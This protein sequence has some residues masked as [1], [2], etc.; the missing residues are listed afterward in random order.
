MYYRREMTTRRLATPPKP[1]RRSLALAASD[2]PVPAKARKGDRNE[3]QTVLRACEVLK[4]FRNLGEELNLSQVIER[5]G[6][7][8]TTVFRLLR[9]LIHGGLLERAGS[10]VYRN[11]FGPVTARPFR[12]GFAAQGDSEFCRE[13]MKSMEV[14]AAREHVHLITVNNR[15]SAREAIRNADILI[16]EQ[17][18]LVLEFQTYERVAPVLSSKF[19]EANV[20]VIA[21][22]IPHPGA[23]YFGAN[24]YKA[25]II[26]GKALGRWARDH[27]DGK[28]DQLLL[29]E[30]PIAGSLLELR[31]TGLVDGLRAELPQITSVPVAHLN[32]RGD[33]EQVLE[34]LRQFLRR[35][36]GKRTLVGAV[37]D[38]CALAALRAFDEIGGRHLCAVMGQNAIPEARAEL[39]RPGTSLIGT[40]AYF[41]ER[42]GDEIMALALQ[43]LQK[44]TPPSTVFVKHQLITARNVDLL[45]PLDAH[46]DIKVGF[47]NPHGRATN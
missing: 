28:V 26:G 27:W 47:P 9:T 32:G 30:L 21:I 22:E 2:E 1:R 11:R 18:D 20:P 15:Y 13:V 45:Y 38:I 4:T 12:I 42:Y 7:P 24:N 31:I 10:G 5:T 36:P 6:L 44:K 23:T 33:F 41:P 25:G 40:V 14:A 3:S 16:K 34:V 46:H 17:V 39:R 35:A 29:L 37:N 8:K 43:I 19:L